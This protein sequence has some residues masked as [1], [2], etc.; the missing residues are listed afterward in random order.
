[1]FCIIIERTRKGKGWKRE[2][3]TKLNKF[4]LF[5]FRN[6][7]SCWNYVC[8]HF[9]KNNFSISQL[10]WK[11][12]AGKN[13]ANEIFHYWFE[14]PFNIHTYAWNVLY[15]FWCCAEKYYLNVSCLQIFLVCLYFG[16]AESMFAF[17]KSVLFF[18]TFVP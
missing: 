15:E 13:I 16:Y 3:A 9:L 2:A 12:E 5:K 10:Q 7:Y 14:I 4:T 11:T 18:W 8:I 6:P 17:K 1:M